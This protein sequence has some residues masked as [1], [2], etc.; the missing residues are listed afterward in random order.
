MEFEELG[1][2][3]FTEYD[4][5]GTTIERYNAYEFIC[6]NCL[7]ECLPKDTELVFSTR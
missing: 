4:R 6:G 5:E 3:V 1:F 7:D 2:N